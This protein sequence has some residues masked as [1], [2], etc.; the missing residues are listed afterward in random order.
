MSNLHPIMQQALAPFIGASFHHGESMTKLQEM[1]AAL[2]AYL[3]QATANGHGESWRKMCSEKTADA[4]FAAAWAAYDAYAAFA[5]GIAAAA[6]AF[7]A[8]DAADADG[9]RADRYAQKAI[10]RIN[11][12]KEIE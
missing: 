12:A 1:W 9:P 8:A 10:D 4:A 11:K 2:L 5:A 3:P 7:A 6:A